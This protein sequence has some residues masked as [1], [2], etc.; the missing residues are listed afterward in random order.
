MPQQLSFTADWAPKEFRGRY[1][2][3][4]S[5]AWSLGIIAN[6]LLL[7]PLHARLGEG[8]FWP[9]VLVVAVPA[10]FLLLHIDRTSDRPELLRGREEP[11][12][13]T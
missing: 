7:L 9:L 10:A 11:S 3:F 1:L 8:V 4:Y 13:A 6:P 5:A 12:L 2:G